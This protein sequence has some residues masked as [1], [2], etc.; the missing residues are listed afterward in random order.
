[1]KIRGSGAAFLSAVSVPVD[2]GFSS[3]HCGVHIIP[4][5]GKDLQ[6]GHLEDKHQKKAAGSVMWSSAPC[7]QQE[8]PCGGQGR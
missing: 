7:V 6:R 1:M 3:T 8:V 4:D 2:G 5:W